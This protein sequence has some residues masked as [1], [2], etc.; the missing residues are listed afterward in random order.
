[1]MLNLRFWLAT[2]V[3][4]TLISQWAAVSAQAATVRT[5]PLQNHPLYI[6]PVPQDIRMG[7][8]TARLEFLETP[9]TN[10]LPNAAELD[11]AAYAKKSKDDA[12]SPAVATPTL[13]D[14]RLD[15]GAKYHR[16][17]FVHFQLK[18]LYKMEGQPVD[19]KSLNDELRQIN[20]INKFAV[21]G[22]LKEDTDGKAVL[23]LTLY[24]QQP[25]E[26]NVTYDNQ[27]RP[28]NGILRTGL[29]FKQDNIL[30]IGDQVKARTV[31]AKGTEFYE[32]SYNMPINRWGGRVDAW[33]TYQQNYT[34]FD[35]NDNLFP[36]AVTNTDENTGWGV[37]VRQPIDKQ[38]L[39]E[40]QAGYAD[41]HVVESTF[42]NTN[43]FHKTNKNDYQIT[44]AGV[45]FNKNYLNKEKTAYTGSTKLNTTIFAEDLLAQDAEL[46]R[47]MV[48][49]QQTFNLPH[50]Q[51]IRLR[52][53]IQ[54]TPL[55]LFPLQ[56]QPVTGA[57]NV[58][59]YNEGALF[60]DS[61]Y[62]SSLEYYFP[63]PGLKRMSP[64]LHEKLRGV[65]FVD[66]AY[67]RLDEE[68]TL[69]VAGT[70]RDTFLMSAGVGLR[71]KFNQHVQGFVDAA[72]GL[73]EANNFV[74]ISSLS[75][76]IG[77]GARVH[78]GIRANVLDR[79]LKPTEQLQRDGWYDSA[80]PKFKPDATV[81]PSQYT[82][83]LLFNPPLS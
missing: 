1:M 71:V 78:F 80:K 59:G 62:F 3:V 66:A 31:Q 19:I 5:T 55:S 47:V 14:I 15:T 4:V 65:A 29:E 35:P 17:G 43:S 56:M 24:E 23:E 46:Y 27:G 7:A 45:E 60:T 20:R 41:R 53:T 61:L 57:L 18:R 72:W 76:D 58:R 39:F 70:A 75:P 73:N 8:D 49:G 21:K 82:T 6:T 42:K 34:R 67:A 81:P 32:L 64:S 10:A 74:G 37:T 25:T 33:G 40:V 68:R 30:G 48:N 13:G 79:G 16:D 50:D 36:N 69:P 12:A 9:L 38:G 26:V 11:A 28:R 2:A 83:P 44:W 54:E 77:P 63:I 51:T 22:T 52:A